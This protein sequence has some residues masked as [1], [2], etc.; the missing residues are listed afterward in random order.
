[1]TEHSARNLPREGET[2]LD[3][4]G[5]FV[6]SAA[7]ASDALAALGFTVTPYSAQVLPDPATGEMTPTGTGNVCV[8]LTE[9]YIEV[10]VHTADTPLGL[11]F[12]AALGRRAGLHLAA[13][14]VAD[15]QSVHARLTDAGWPMRP[16]ARFS[17]KAAT[18]TG[19]AE[20]RFT[21]ARLEKGTMA[22]G[23]VQLVTH[24]DEAVIWQPRWLDHANTALGLGAM[25]IAAPDP[26]EAAGRFARLVGRPVETRGAA[27]VVSVDRGTIEVV[28]EAEGERLAGRRIAPGEPAIVGYR[29]RV[30]D[31]GRSA[32][33][34]AASG[35]PFEQTGG[36][37]VTAFPEALGKGV[38]LFAAA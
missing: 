36:T 29:I 26:A 21:V 11:E 37:I 16:L 14:A 3:H 34:L 19:E 32:S 27:R 35:L 13:F 33:C 30:G 20:A 10:L 24:H 18:P 28:D 15:A 23:R 31:I 4:I 2:T 12:K 7:D 38:M 17:R 8:M 1:M 22:E 6:P 25:I 5:H 9:G